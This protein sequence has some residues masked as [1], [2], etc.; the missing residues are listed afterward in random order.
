M[1]QEPQKVERRSFLNYAVAIIATGVVVGAGVYLLKPSVTSTVTSTVAGPTSTKTVTST[2]SGAGGT[3]TVTVTSGGAGTT[4]TVP[5]TI[6]TGSV[7]PSVT[8]TIWMA[9][10]GNVGSSFWAPCYKGV[11]DAINW[12]SASGSATINF[13]HTYT[14][15]DYAKQA[16]DLKSAV[17]SKPDGILITVPSDPTLL[18]PTV[19]DGVSKGI[20][21]IALNANDQR[22]VDQ[23]M[24]YLFY[25]GENAQLVGPAMGLDLNRYITAHPGAF[26]PAN[27][28]LCNPVSG[29]IIWETR[30]RLYGQYMSTTWGTT[31]VTQVTGVDATKF[32]DIIRS[33][34]T[35]YPK[36][37]LISASGG[38]LDV[39]WPVLT[40]A[41][42]TPGKDIYVTGFDPT[43][44]CMTHMA[45]GTMVNCFDQQQYLQGFIPLSQMFMYLAHSFSIYG[46]VATGPYII[47]ETN[48]SKV[49]ASTKGGYR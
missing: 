15:E 42:K 2:V 18:D 20:G 6:I 12:L 48:V 29:H 7:T 14:N 25:V 5:T 35:Q 13:K 28:L 8:Y 43:A 41:G 46:T 1:S 19:R 38:M 44:T 30:L 49:V 27:A 21:F 32:P 3:S 23:M 17:A 22:P 4:V 37:D 31:V 40:E 11:Q 10:H 33:L 39:V 34:L 47:N 9:D 36:T 24:P 45:D 26:K 16:D